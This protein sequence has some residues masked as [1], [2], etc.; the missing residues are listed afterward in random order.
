M[1]DCCTPGSGFPTAATM[2]QLATNHPVVWKEICMI[3]QA[4]LEASSQCQPGGGQFCTLVGGNTP[5]TFIAGVTSVDVSQTLPG[6]APSYELIQSTTGQTVVNTVVSTVA[7]ANGI[8]YLLVFVNG[9]LQ[10]ESLSFNVSSPTQLTFIAPL[11]N[12]DEIAIYSYS[13]GVGQGGGGGYIID[14]P[15]VYFVPPVGV[16]PTVVASATITTNGGN[17]LTVNVTNP[18][19][20]YQP[21]PSTL[22]ISSVA[23]LGASLVPL[24]N[25]AGQIVNV[26]IS[27]PGVGYTTGDT[28]IA[29]RA[30][31]PNAAYIDAILIITA[32]SLT[33]EIIAVAVLNPGSGYENSIT[34]IRIVSALNPALPYPQGGSFYGSVLTNVA[35][36][37]IGVVVNNTGAG[38]TNLSPYLVITDPGTGATTKVTLT[39]SSVSS[40]TVTS[41]GTGYT[42][43]AIGTVFNPVTAPGPNPPADPALVK[44]NVSK[45]TFGTNPG[46]YWQV[47]QGA[48]T[49]RGIQL[50]LNSVL[51]YFKGLGYTILIQTNPSSGSSIAWK[52]CW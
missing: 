26:N 17:I 5:M 2:Q 12:A 7:A 23:G 15:S 46:L 43:N 24:V 47:W 30:V 18:G 11:G 19:A 25:A 42:Q 13:A 48:A 35:G 10:I 27:A 3:Q 4:L 31:L 8:S 36:N 41:P 38:Y 32:V 44:V 34:K 21:V 14:T 52:I 50:Q 29:H 6:V 40:I 45:N 37:I 28:L 22:S 39:G 51:A 16:V 33:G 1:S 49:N 9:L 20:G